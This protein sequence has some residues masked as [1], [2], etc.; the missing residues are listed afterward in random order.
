MSFRSRPQS[1]SHRSR[2]S[3][4][5][6]ATDPVDPTGQPN[7]GAEVYGDINVD[8]V[9]DIMDV[10]AINKFLLGARTLEGTALANADVD[11]NKT[12]DTND[13]MNILKCALGIIDKL[14]TFRL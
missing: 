5:K 9:V 10:I 2:P 13:A 11:L 3:L 8:G 7:T 4:K 1:R 6:T 12:L 14:P